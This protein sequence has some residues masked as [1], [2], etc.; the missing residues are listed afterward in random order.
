M[1]IRI[2][3]RHES[4]KWRR[5]FDIDN[6]VSFEYKTDIDYTMGEDGML[7]GPGGVSVT[8]TGADYRYPVASDSIKKAND[9]RIIQ[10]QLD[11]EKRKREESDRHIKELEDKQKAL[12][13]KPTTLKQKPAGDGEN[14]LAGG[15]SIVYSLV[16]YF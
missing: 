3:N 1:N 2:N 13:N 4:K 12:Q 16:Q 9:N 10:E 5:R 8:N 14:N 15:P 7:K 11:N 6:D